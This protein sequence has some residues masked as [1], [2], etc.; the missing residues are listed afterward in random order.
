MEEHRRRVRRPLGLEARQVQLHRQHAE[1]PVVCIAER[2]A[3]IIRNLRAFAR[4]E[5][6]P[7]A[8]VSLA[9]V[10]AD[11]LEILAP[12]IAAA[13]AAVE[14]PD[15]PVP[16]VHGGRVRLQQVLINLVSNSIDAMEGQ[17][18]PRHVRIGAAVRD[19]RVRLTVRDSGPGLTDPD[20]IFDPFF[21]TK[22]VGAGLGLGL[23][24][25]Y[26]IVQSFGGDIRAEN[27]DGGGAMFTIDLPA[28][29][30]DAAA[31]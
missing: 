13:G 15:G 19:G 23:S 6:E 8:D 29:R 25:S 17:D 14:A 5:A 18:G 10:I 11:A 31:A 7:A 12:R 30:G 4:N 20:R 26:G 27:C 28:A 1:D 3:R 24:I 9:T 16:A 2:A 21:T 22:P